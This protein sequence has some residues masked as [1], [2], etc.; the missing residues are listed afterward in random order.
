MAT[1][2]H[3]LLCAHYVRYGNIICSAAFFSIRL[4]TKFLQNC[5]VINITCMVYLL[6]SGM[7]ILGY[8]FLLTS[9]MH[10]HVP[11]FSTST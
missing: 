11:Y 3:Q 7:M 9:I 6:S 2:A 5:N 8:I 10:V 1:L 4:T